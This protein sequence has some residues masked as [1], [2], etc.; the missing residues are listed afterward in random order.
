[1]G[2]ERNAAQSYRLQ[3]MIR[4]DCDSLLDLGCGSG[5]WSERIAR[6][7]PWIRVTGV[8]FGQPFIEKAQQRYRLDNLQFRREDFGELSFPDATFD[9]VYAD[10]TIEHAF[11]V[12]LALREVFRVLRPNGTLVAALPPDG[13]NPDR[14]CDNHTWKTLPD[15]VRQ[16]LENAGF[17]DVG[18]HELDTYRELAMPPYPPSENRMMYIRAWKREQADRAPGPSTAHLVRVMAW[19]YKHVQPADPPEAEIEPFRVLSAR[20]ALCLGYALT[21]GELLERDGW[22]VEY[23]TLLARDHERGRGKD[24]I[25]SHELLQVRERGGAAVVLDP[26]ANTLLACDLLELLRNPS[27]AKA[28]QDP[29]ARY[30]ERRYDLYDTS[31]FYERAFEA[32]VRTSPEVIAYDSEGSW[33][34][35]LKA[36]GGLG[37]RRI[38]RK[39]A[40]GS[41]RRALLPLDPRARTR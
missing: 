32:C 21:L 12:D 30:R 23:V 1:M 17:V 10:N 33:R 8:D 5:Y 19:L 11:D 27:L 34:A 16:R 6:M 41:W 13:R 26:M 14:T 4:W 20:K 2:E 38:Y 31:Y 9:V 24:R 25:D 36:T 40:D 37:R 22:Q 18:V 39:G 29:D 28:K 15:D 7:H 3:E 35:M